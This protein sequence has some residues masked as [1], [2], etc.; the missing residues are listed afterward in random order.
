MRM[1]DNDTRPLDVD[2][3]GI[4]TTVSAQRS[5]R[6]VLRGAGGLLGGGLVTTMAGA[7]RA[8]AQDNGGLDVRT[9]DV[10][11]LDE[12]RG[13]IR[14]KGRVGGMSNYDCERCEVGAHVQPVGDD[15]WYGGMQTVRHTHRDSFWVRVTLVGLRPGR[16]RCRLCA[17]PITRDTVF[18]AN[19]LVIVIDGDDRKH[20]KGKHE[21]KHHKHKKAY[22]RRCPCRLHH[23]NRY[24][25]MVCGGGGTDVN[26]YA[27]KVSSSDI[28]RVG[29]SN[30]PDVIADRHVTIDT[31]DYVNGT[32][33]TGA[34]AGGGDSY[35]CDG[36]LE[37][38]RTDRGTS[39]Y[40]NGMEVEVA[41]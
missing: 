25:L 14:T 2:I 12:Q 22:E 38:I 31:E 27:F 21:K 9:T 13:E 28:E 11:V 32:I 34:V 24:H 33:V 23:P 16:Y 26:E 7:E 19:I 20:K 41:H 1:S 15:R 30:A 40:I 17:C 3:D 37:D 6:N 4:T 18:T 36:Y 35:I 39:V 29:V 10:E 5:R 8:T